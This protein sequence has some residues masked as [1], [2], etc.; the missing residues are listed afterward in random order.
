[1]ASK[2]FEARYY[3]KRCPECGWPVEAG[4]MAQFNDNG[5]FVH[6]RCCSD[7]I[8]NPYFDNWWNK[9]PKDVV[10]ASKDVLTTTKPK[11]A[12]QPAPAPTPMEEDESVTIYCYLCGERLKVKPI[13]RRM[14][15]NSAGYLVV[16]FFQDEVLAHVCPQ[17]S[18][19]QDR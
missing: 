4:E 2:P 18:R 9:A 3:N 19:L 6:E 14:H 7:E 12:S 5:E 10:Q 16:E 17:L 13:V 1:M 15:F 11:P 8:T